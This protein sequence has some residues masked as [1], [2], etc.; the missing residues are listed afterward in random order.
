MDYIVIEN[1][2][3]YAYHGVLPE[4]KTLG[5]EFLV[6]LELGLDLSSHIKDKIEA[7]ADY[8]QA[9]QFTEEIMSGKPC[10][11]IET[12]ACRIA[13]KLLTIAKVQAVKV[14][15]CKPNPP[16]PSVRGG[17]KAVINRKK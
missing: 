8:R 3:I 4:E 6:N 17:I 7:V 9:V 5:Q 15:V 10:V 16:I 13:D 14:E 11:L 12:L 2:N 1:I